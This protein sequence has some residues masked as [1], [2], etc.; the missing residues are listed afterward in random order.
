MKSL[1]VYYV[2]LGYEN[3]KTW[4][5]I[6]KITNVRHELRS[7]KYIF[8]QMKLHKWKQWIVSDEKKCIFS[9][10]YQQNIAEIA[11]YTTKTSN[12]NFDSCSR[13]FENSFHYDKQ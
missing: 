5:L 9:V 3:V 4:N 8:F 13:I 11:E 12:F 2:I 10:R 7:E 1:A 6:T